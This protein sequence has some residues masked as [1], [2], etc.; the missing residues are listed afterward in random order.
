MKIS[1]FVW[2]RRWQFPMLL[3]LSVM[4]AALASLCIHAPKAL[5]S[6]YILFAA[7]VLLS[8]VCVAMPG[9]KRL[10]AAIVSCVLLIA[11]SFGVLAIRAYPL[12]L[13]LPSALGA[14]LL[15]SLPL[16]VRQYESEV[17]PYI[18][19]I[20]IG[21]H[22]VFQ[23]LHHYFIRISGS[24]PYEPAARALTLSLILYIVLLL[25]SLN[26]ISLDNASLAR[27]RLPASM[28]LFNTILTLCF[29]AI[30]LILAALPS[31]VLAVHSLWRAI[32]G[33]IVHLSSWLLSFLPDA[34]DLG[35]MGGGS[36]GGL[37]AVPM[38]EVPTSA[39]AQLMQKAATILSMAIL[40]CG[41]LFLC[42]LLARQLLRLFRHLSRRLRTYMATAS[43]EY[44]D[45]ITDT[46]EDGAQRETR[47]LLKTRRRAEQ[48]P[49]TPAGRVRFAYARLLRRRP[50][51]TASSTAREN[52][53]AS[54]AEIYE[55]ARYSRHPVTTQDAQHF[56]AQIRAE[57]KG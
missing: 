17:P 20:G 4:P 47:F 25:L 57:K 16:A 33:I 41:S 35:G 19:V 31:V 45:E 12:F 5:L 43:S 14:L 18:Y 28:R 49:D 2:L 22:V 1:F 8:G 40:V 10:P 29:T 44:D 23:F 56:D 37:P 52:L 54:A 9:A 26:R 15:Y 6:S 34:P 24:S 42:Y 39:F 3:L 32:T 48:A 30:C 51:W 11:L 21:V 36:M 50:Q 38:E 46:R 13:L 53:P 55:R 7:Y 27:H